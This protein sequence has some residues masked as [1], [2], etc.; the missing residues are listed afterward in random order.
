MC[1][2]VINLR[3]VVLFFCFNPFGVIR[4]SELVS[5]DT[6][7]EHGLPEALVFSHNIL[8]ADS[9]FVNIRQDICG[10]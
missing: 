9:V 10:T 5:D 8:G 7:V 6:N 2:G 4:V 1:L 3:H